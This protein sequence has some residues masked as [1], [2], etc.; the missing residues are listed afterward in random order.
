MA[1][2]KKDVIK[3]V[4]DAFARNDVE[5]FLSFCDDDFVWTMVG[6]DPIKG[7]DAV[8]KWMAS[9]PPEP[10][11]FTVNTVVAEGDVVTSIGDM[12]MTENGKT[13]PYAYCD[14]WR[15]RGDKIVEL[16]A[17]VIKTAAATV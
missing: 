14:V 11:N 17:F 6:S 3:H 4:D 10:P 9:G 16:R 15:F 7:K 1:L 5:R 13:V 8:R 12:T 2:S